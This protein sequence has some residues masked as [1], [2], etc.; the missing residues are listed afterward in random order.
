MPSLP[1][2]TVYVGQFRDLLIERNPPPTKHRLAAEMLHSSVSV[3]TTAAAPAV[4]AGE[5]EEKEQEIDCR[6]PS[7]HITK[8]TAQRGMH[9]EPQGM[10][11][12]EWRGEDGLWRHKP[13]V[14]LWESVRKYL[15][16]DL[17]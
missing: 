16:T 7:H 6:S 14:C 11:I 2:H 4:L 13:T 10:E 1:A 15:N 8:G 17:S 3:L 5:V 12:R 9:K